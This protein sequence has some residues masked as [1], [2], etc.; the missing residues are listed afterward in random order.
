MEI[1]LVAIFIL[2][3]LLITLEHPL[4]LDKTVPAL[5]MAATLWG[6][7]AIG[8]H[9]G[10]V[11]IV[12]EHQ[13]MHSFLEGAKEADDAFKN[14]LLHHLAKISEILIPSL[15]SIYSSRSMKSY[16]KTSASSRPTADFPEP[17]YPNKT[18]FIL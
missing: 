11:D 14:S 5:I 13:H 7:L 15:D 12:D 18:T 2:G 9:L 16:S 6:L 1:T 10:W 17:I 8:F 4:R 3:Y